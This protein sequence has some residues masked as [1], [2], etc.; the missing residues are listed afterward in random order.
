MGDV[1]AIRTKVDAIHE[2]I[3]EHRGFRRAMRAV[4]HGVLVTIGGLGGV[5]LAKL[6]R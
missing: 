3:V 2:V 5:L 6:W 4:G 1:R